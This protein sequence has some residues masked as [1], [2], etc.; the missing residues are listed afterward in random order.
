MLR[1]SAGQ[2]GVW[3]LALGLVV[4]LAS[5]G[6]AD[7]KEKKAPAAKAA[8]GDAKKPG[9]RLPA[10]YG[11]VVDAAQREKIYAIQKDFDPKMAA[12]KAQLAALAKE[13]NEKIEALLTPEQRNKIAQ[14]KAAAD[15]KRKDAGEK[16]EKKA[17]KA[18]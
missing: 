18:K 1:S 17:D 13:Q 7:D 2:L 3:L 16:V 8:R 12:L 11:D 10:H 5:Q 14:L 15:A 9:G 6:R 4:G